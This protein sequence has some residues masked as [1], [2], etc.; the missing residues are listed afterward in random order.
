MS[1]LNGVI[2]PSFRSQRD[3][4]IISTDRER[5]LY[6]IPSFLYA[7]LLYGVYFPLRSDFLFEMI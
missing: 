2:Y 5:A 3:Y 6:E 1:S 7:S 4:S